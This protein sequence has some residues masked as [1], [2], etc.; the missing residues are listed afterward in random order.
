[1]SVFV[2]RLLPLPPPDPQGIILCSPGV[3]LLISKLHV[4]FYSPIS[5]QH[6]LFL[7]QG[8]HSILWSFHICL[9]YVKIFIIYTYQKLYLILYL[10]DVRFLSFWVWLILHSDWDLVSLSC[11]LFLFPD[12]IHMYPKKLPNKRRKN[13]HIQ[14]SIYIY[15]IYI[16][17]ILNSSRRSQAQL[18]VKTCVFPLIKSLRNRSVFSVKMDQQFSRKMGNTEG[19]P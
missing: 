8:C 14:H 15:T 9:V 16:Y 19:R 18:I 11:F 2:L 1:M 5:I 10:R 3:P 4:L 6:C 12:F 13:R 7:S 17:N